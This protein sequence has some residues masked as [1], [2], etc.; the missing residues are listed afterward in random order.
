MPGSIFILKIFPLLRSVHVY[1]AWLDGLRLPLLYWTDACGV[2]LA[3][4]G[5][6]DKGRYWKYAKKRSAT[7]KHQNKTESDF[8]LGPADDMS[9]GG[10]IGMGRLALMTCFCEHCVWLGSSVCEYVLRVRLC[11]SRKTGKYAELWYNNQTHD[12]LWT[13][14][15]KL[16]PFYAIYHSLL[17]L[18]AMNAAGVGSSEHFITILRVYFNILYYAL[19]KIQYICRQSLVLFHLLAEL[20]V[21]LQHCT[22]SYIYDNFADGP[23]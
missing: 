2:W 17:P 18:F 16:P 1:A 11:E 6:Y 13:R 20:L 23:L 4:A 22:Y 3:L 10:M 14:V 19:P 9:W 12:I 21:L 7:I 5:V 15:H 8:F